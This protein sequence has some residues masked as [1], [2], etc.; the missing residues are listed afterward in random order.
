M[1]KVG[2]KARR[3]RLW[4]ANPHC[5]YCNKYLQ[6]E[7]TTIDHVIPRSKGGKGL[8]HKDNEVLSCRRCNQLKRDCTPDDIE[9]LLNIL[10]KLSKMEHARKFVGCETVLL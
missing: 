10:G 7:E 4:L 8:Q 2:I 9:E 5:K 6:W 1:S 3:K